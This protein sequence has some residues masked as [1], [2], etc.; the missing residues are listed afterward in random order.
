MVPF[1]FTDSKHVFSQRQNLVAAIVNPTFHVCMSNHWPSAHV[2]FMSACQL[3]NMQC[4]LCSYVGL[5]C[6]GI[7]LETVE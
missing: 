3:L 1:G 7:C 2:M 5:G 6:P 4:S